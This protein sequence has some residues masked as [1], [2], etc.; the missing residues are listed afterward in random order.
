MIFV[1]NPPWLI[2]T[3]I[4]SGALDQPFLQGRARLARQRA[5]FVHWW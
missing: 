2:P 3:P 5:Q 1:N 4:G